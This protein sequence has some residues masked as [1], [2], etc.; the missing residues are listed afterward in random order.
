MVETVL[1]PVPADAAVALG[2]FLSHRGVTSPLGV[3]LT[4]WI[5]NTVGAIGVYAVA[6][7]IGSGL[8]RR[9]LGQRLLSPAAI[10]FV[11][12]EYIRF[13]VAGIFF[14]RLLPGIRAVVPPFAGLVRLNPWRALLP[15]AAASGLWYGGLTLAGAALGSE[16]ETIERFLSGLNRTLGI[17]AA[18]LIVAGSIWLIR[19]RRAVRRRLWDTF[20]RALA[21]APVPEGPD[22]ERTLEA[23]A[24]LIL[25]MAYVDEMLPAGERA[26]VESRLRQRWKLTTALA[27]PAMSAERARRA[28]EEHAER[29]SEEYGP[30]ARRALIGR[31]WQVAMEDGVMGE[32]EARMIQRAAALLGIAPNDLADLERGQG[33]AARKAGESSPADHGPR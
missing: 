10:A 26:R 25:E 30:E 22:G 19:H 31:M 28:L 29:A 2:A 20:Q 12:R 3:F 14:G 9:P 15:M 32:H 4:C 5:A 27:F 7:R 18:V 1:P 11:E 13:G 16:W 23:V 24:A 17:V 21:H 6:Y 33:G 8:F